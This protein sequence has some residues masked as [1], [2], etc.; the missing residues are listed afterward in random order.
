MS[1][2]AILDRARDAGISLTPKPDGGIRAKGPPEAI[3]GLLPLLRAHKEALLQLLNE[4][5]RRWLVRHEDQVLD[6]TFTPPLPWAEVWAIRPDALTID[7]VPEHEPTGEPLP[8]SEEE[9]VRRWL[10][11]ID[12]RDP[13]IIGEVL[14]RCQADAKARDWYLEQAAQLESNS[15]RLA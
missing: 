15:C 3:D 1:A 14:Q 6:V 9:A 12:E 11:A 4:P 8:A 10:D 2:A 13:L 5:R 7:P